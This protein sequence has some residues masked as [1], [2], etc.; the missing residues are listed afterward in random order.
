MPESFANLHVLGVTDDGKA[1]HT[2]R[3]PAG[4]TPFTMI[5]GLP[6]PTVDPVVDVAC[7]RCV[8]VSGQTK[9][10]T[11]GLWALVAMRDSPPR[12]LFRNSD[13]S[14]WTATNTTLPVATGVAVTVSPGAGSRSFVHLAVVSKATSRIVAAIAPNDVQAPGSTINVTAEVQ[15]NGAGDIGPALRVALAP[16]GLGGLFPGGPQSVALLGVVFG[17]NS[18]FF[19]VGGVSSA[20]TG[21]WDPF[22]ARDLA[23]PRGPGGRPGQADDVAI[24]NAS[25]FPLIISDQKEYT[26]IVRGGPDPDIYG[27]SLGSD[28]WSSWENFEIFQLPGV[29]VDT[30]PAVFQRLDM[31]VTTQ[32]LNVVGS[33][34]GG[35]IFYQL[36]TPPFPAASVFRDVELIGGSEVGYFVPVACG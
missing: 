10:K 5:P 16:G 14:A 12:L 1:W 18:L 35:Q 31:S 30:E 7:V 4:F 15:T 32:G 34:F 9:P 8:P 23:P 13:T 3:S 26:G 36:R 11:E 22:R 25:P 20:G 24:A 33:G 2:V 29:V 19:T 27:A 17:D 21:R 6:D 28:G